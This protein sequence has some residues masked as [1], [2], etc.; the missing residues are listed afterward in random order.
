MLLPGWKQAGPIALSHGRPHLLIGSVQ[1][2]N[3]KT[4]KV[5]VPLDFATPD[6]KAGGVDAS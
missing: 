4:R 1:N 2:D 6:G 3:L 5:A